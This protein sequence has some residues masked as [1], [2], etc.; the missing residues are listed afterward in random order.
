MKNKIL[1]IT[2]TAVMLALLVVVQYVTSF[3]PKPA[4]Q[5]ITGSCVN[6][7]LAVTVL[8]CGFWSGAA[9]AAVSPF[10]AFLFGIG[11]QLLPI[12]PAI[13]AGN[14]VFVGLL[15]LIHG[16]TPKLLTKLLAWLAAAVGKFT[17]LY[18][19][20]VQLLCNVLPLKQPQI[21]TFT[22]MFSLPQLIT[23]L[24]GGGVAILIIPVLKK[25]IR[26]V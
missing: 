3:I 25:A 10:V 22:A 7:V 4:Q 20:V 6:A 1:W 5:Y 12:V 16:S 14:L 24:I 26:K 15:H 9:V 23:A 2:R 8:M 18:L 11:P 13:A 17:A 21:D 19:L